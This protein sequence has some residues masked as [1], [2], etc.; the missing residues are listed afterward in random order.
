M[1]SAIRSSSVSLVSCDD[2]FHI[3]HRHVTG[4]RYPTTLDCV[5]FFAY[6]LQTETN[7]VSLKDYRLSD[8]DSVLQIT[9]PE[10]L[11]IV[12]QSLSLL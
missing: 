10:C 9:T 1:R 11:K 2:R 12:K 6:P 7:V 3:R 5:C 8:I 4:M